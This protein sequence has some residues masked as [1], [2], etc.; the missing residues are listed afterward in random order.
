MSSPMMPPSL[1][2]T[3]LAVSRPSWSMSASTSDV[4]RSYVMGVSSMLER[5]CPRLSTTITWWSSEQS[6]DLVRPILAVGKAAME[7]D[8]RVDRS[9]R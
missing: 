7:Q 3:M 5:P 4:I 1:Q 6:W 8:H 9:H 2:P